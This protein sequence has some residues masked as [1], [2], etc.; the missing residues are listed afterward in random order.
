[1]GSFREFLK[2]KGVWIEGLCWSSFSQLPGNFTDIDY[3]PQKQLVVL[4]IHERYGRFGNNVL[5]LLHALLVARNLS[6]NRI[7][8]NFYID[9][10]RTNSII[11][12]DMLIEF[13]H[14]QAPAAPCLNATMFY[15]QG[16]EKFIASF[17]LESVKHDAERLFRALFQN[18]DVSKVGNKKIVAFH[19]R[20]GDIFSTNK[21]PIYTQ[22]PLSYYEKVLDH[23]SETMDNFQIY[24]VYEDELNPCIQKFRDTL[25]DRNIPYRNQ[26]SNFNDDAVLIASAE[27]IVASY[28]S[29]CDVLALMNSNLERWYSFRSI[30]A[31]EG[32]ELSIARD[33]SRILQNDGAELFLVED[34]NNDYIPLGKWTYSE[35]QREQL[36]T[37]PIKNL[38]LKVVNSVCP[39][40]ELDK[41]RA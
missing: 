20:A 1:M 29:F 3:D 9:D 36:L 12:D 25:K 30:G 23:I 10:S 14:K 7:Y 39:V 19:F 33:F 40:S 31:Y 2:N 11:L 5:Q 18:T 4:Y 17:K 35:L 6:I 37:Y 41:I 32:I 27:C 13:G 24:L 34:L 22:P 16:F 28:S 21:N 8:C 38:A 15:L 26:S